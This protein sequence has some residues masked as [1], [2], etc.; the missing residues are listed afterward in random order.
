MAVL[1]LPQPSLRVTEIAMA[2]TSPV[3]LLMTQNQLQ[4]FS[5]RRAVCRRLSCRATEGAGLWVDSCPQ[6]S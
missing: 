1:A 4:P 5:P 2:G 6:L 3:I